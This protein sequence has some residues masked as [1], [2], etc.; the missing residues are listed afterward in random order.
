METKKTKTPKM[1]H[2][3]LLTM[4]AKGDSEWSIAFPRLNLAKMFIKNKK[5]NIKDGCYEGVKSIKY[6]IKRFPFYCEDVVFVETMMDALKREYEEK[7]P[8][9]CSLNKMMENIINNKGDILKNE[10]LKDKKLNHNLAQKRY[11]RKIRNKRRV[12][13]YKKLYKEWE[14]LI[15]NP[16]PTK[17]AHK[18]HIKNIKKLEAKM[19]KLR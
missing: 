12:I 19:S 3:Y 14:D 1:K 17:I 8:Q 15:S 13:K 5:L 6:N 2:I 10:G 9:I 7:K 16:V 4:R 11:Y 18:Y